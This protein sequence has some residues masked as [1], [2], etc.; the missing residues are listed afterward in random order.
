MRLGMTPHPG[1]G[2]LVVIEGPDGSGKTTLEAGLL[3]RMDQHGVAPRILLQPTTWWRDDERVRPRWWATRGARPLGLAAFSIAD[4]LD[5]QFHV[6]EP[7][8]L[9]GEVLL[10]NRYL[11]SLSAHY[12]TTDEVDQGLFAP[13]YAQIIRPDVL[14]VLD[15]PTDVLL[16]RVVERD[17]E[18]RRRWDQQEAFVARNRT[19]FRQLA[20]DNDA[21]LLE[22]VDDPSDLVERCGRGW[23]RC[24]PSGPPS[25]RGPD[26]HSP[27]GMRRGLHGG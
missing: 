12:L 9:A 22:S 21:L 18:D 7:A 25:S 11:L 23:A 14:V 8:L 20:Q 27:R 6:V 13:L 4:R 2:V 10:S 3:D 26:A 5:H 15:A 19:A 24:S 16:Q 1:P 17:G